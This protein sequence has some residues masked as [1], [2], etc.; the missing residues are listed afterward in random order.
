MKSGIIGFEQ[1]R[2]RTQKH[3]IHHSS[4]SPCPT[5]IDQESDTPMTNSSHETSAEE[6][7][8]ILRKLD[9]LLRKHQGI[10]PNS[11]L[12]KAS[13]SAGAHS[14]PISFSGA[15]PEQI[16]LTAADNIP[17]LTEVVHLV[18]SML[19][20]YSDITALLEQIL[21]SALNDANIEL[22]SEARKT[23]VQA[24]ESRLFGL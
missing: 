12:A 15:A 5:L 6:Y 4:R 17:T 2:A 20:P 14:R 11:A 19:S 8:A 13:A 1:Y 24:L 21:D 9:I 10:S 18:P 7:D 23:L 22:S 3:A 16:S